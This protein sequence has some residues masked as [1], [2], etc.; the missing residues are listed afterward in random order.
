MFHLFIKSKNND[1]IFWF[2]DADKNY[3]VH[4]LS[5]SLLLFM[6]CISTFSKSSKESCSA[7]SIALQEIICR[8]L[9]PTK[10]TLLYLHHQDLTINP[11]YQKS[12][13]LFS[14]PS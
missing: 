3:I 9:L 5:P 13:H 2:S 10:A 8:K 6:I 7:F 4:S 14:K 12:S 11:Q 1:I